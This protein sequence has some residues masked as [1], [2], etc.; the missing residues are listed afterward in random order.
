[1]IS[2]GCGCPMY[3]DSHEVVQT[4]TTESGR[5][6]LGERVS[7][8]RSSSVTQEGEGA[9]LVG[10]EDIIPFDMGQQGACSYGSSWRS[11]GEETL[12]TEEAVAYWLYQ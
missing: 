8:G 7:V 10:Y 4:F 5:L 1:M 3:G 6:Q 11:I 12:V 2:Y 9:Y